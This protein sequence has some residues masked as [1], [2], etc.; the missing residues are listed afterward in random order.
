MLHKT[1]RK[2]NSSILYQLERD[3]LSG[4]F[5]HRARQRRLKEG[6][7]C[8]RSHTPMHTKLHSRLWS[9]CFV[10]FPKRA[11]S[12]TIHEMKIEL[13]EGESGDTKDDKAK[14]LNTSILIAVKMQYGIQ[15]TE[16]SGKFGACFGYLESSNRCC[17]Y[18][19]FQ[20]GL[21]IYPLNVKTF[22]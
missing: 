16:Y 6:R 8:F 15:N 5:N 19:L 4:I 18:I 22:I 11:C 2:F 20:R 3:G 10:Q 13:G 7:K 12:E 1:E 9:R 14:P 17:I 21:N